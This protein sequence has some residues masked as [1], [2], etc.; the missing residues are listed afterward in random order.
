MLGVKS[1]AELASVIASVGL[2]QNFAAM[3]A[4]ATEGIQRGHMRLHGRNIAVMAGAVGAEIDIIAKTMADEH[5]VRVDYAKEL[6]EK[7][8][9]NKK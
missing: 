2:A 1:A 8:R 9:A 6:I 4:L 3:R 5:K 7:M